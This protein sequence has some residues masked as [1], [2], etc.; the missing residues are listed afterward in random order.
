MDGWVCLR[1]YSVISNMHVSSYD[2][3]QPTHGCFH[4]VRRV[5]HNHHFFMETLPK[6]C[7]FN[8]ICTA[9]FI[10]LL[11]QQLLID[12]LLYANTVVNT[13][14]TM[15]NSTWQNHC[16][17]KACI[18]VWDAYVPKINKQNNFRIYSVI[19]GNKLD[20]KLIVCGCG[21]KCF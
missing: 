4:Y 2:C 10:H 18:M 15:V 21:G 16:P 9:P 14:D 3:I 6:D 1:R 12:Y 20:D 8:A 17:H 5:L 13:G 11:I 19:K 7:D